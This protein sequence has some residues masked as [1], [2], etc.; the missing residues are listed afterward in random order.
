M[1]DDPPLGAKGKAK[2]VAVNDAT[3]SGFGEDLRK[4]NGVGRQ[5]DHHQQQQQQEHGHIINESGSGSGGGSGNEN[6]RG[7]IETDVSDW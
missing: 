5:Q 7:G 3:E 6:G 2:K 1:A 4:I